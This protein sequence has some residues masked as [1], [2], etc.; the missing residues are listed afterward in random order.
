MAEK[1]R[2]SKNRNLKNGERQRSDGR[3]EYRYQDRYGN[4]HSTYSWRLVPTDKAPQGKRSN[5]SLREL[6]DEIAKAEMAGVLSYDAKNT[7]LNDMVDIFL[8]TKKLRP[9]SISHYRSAYNKYARE[10]IGKLPLSKVSYAMVK[11]RYDEIISETASAQI[12]SNVHN[13]I[14]PAMDLAIENLLIR[15]NPIANAYRRSVEDNAEL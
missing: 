8:Q 12:A 15:A 1:R 3:Y 4:W 2:D 11:R 5:K 9:Q 10:N 13:T 6:E 7:T 14:C